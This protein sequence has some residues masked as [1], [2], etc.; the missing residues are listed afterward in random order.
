MKW[1]SGRG[2]L[3][4]L[5]I[6][7]VWIATA[8]TQTQSPPAS[9]TAAQ[10]PQPS[11]R[12]GVAMVPVDV[13]VL[14]ANG[15]PVTDLRQD[16]FIVEE[17]GARQAISI[18]LPHRFEPVPVQAG[19]GPVFRSPAT[20]QVS[21]QPGRVFLIAFGRGRL[22]E[23]AGGVDGVIHLVRDRLLPQDQVAVMA[24]NRA[25]DFT[26]D[27]A[28]ILEVLERIRRQH[29]TIEHQIAYQ[30]NDLAAVYGRLDYPENVQRA[31]EAIFR[32]P[33]AVPSRR[34]GPA[35][36]QGP[37]TGM[38][39]ALQKPP[40][41]EGG[42]AGGSGGTSAAA[43]AAQAGGDKVPAGSAMADS[44][45]GAPHLPVVANLS[46]RDHVSRGVQVAHDREKLLTGIDYLRRLEGE[47]H[48]IFLTESGLSSVADIGVIQRANSA[49]VAIDVIQT[50]G[51]DP[52]PG[53]VNAREAATSMP[54]MSVSMDSIFRIGALKEMAAETGGQSAIVLRASAA[55]DRIDESTR[56]DYLLGY[57][58]TDATVDAR[59]RRISIRVTRPAL[60]VLYRH[61]YYANQEPPPIDRR[62]WQTEQRLSAAG[63]YDRDI[64]DIPVQ[65]RNWTYRETGTGGVL[66]VDLTVD[67]VRMALPAVDQQRTG[68]LDVVVAAADERSRVV[69]QAR[70]TL[71]LKF[72][73]DVY[74][75]YLRKGVP[76]SVSVPVSTRPR[77]IKVVVYD[78]A[79]DLLG[80]A[81][82]RLW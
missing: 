78:F 82:L 5:G 3:S 36:P 81:L 59:Y 26:N 68:A 28:K 21:A 40:I 46:L 75:T 29:A 24:W 60:T 19:A 31:V 7:L 51:I 61:G 64:T 45:M 66:T 69:G 50:G 18:F 11:F 57:R 54:S 6:A 13:R 38:A 49:R 76:F 74:R 71:D 41:P 2:V 9:A 53:P 62:A 30:V 56:F 35:V 17:D 79:A 77:S 23:P 67:P 32:W 37:L 47:K 27:H 15:K 8:S 42:G 1:M 55:V 39:A 16:E 14:D 73:E 33:G 20:A 22:Q 34:V 70:T 43:M 10:A 80:S 52:G 44:G 63:T 72:G 48:L 58:S 65:L 4:A 12:G 25:T